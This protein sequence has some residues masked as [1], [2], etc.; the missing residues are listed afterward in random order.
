MVSEFRI[1]FFNRLELLSVQGFFFA[2]KLHPFFSA[3]NFSQSSAC[4]ELGF[5]V[6]RAQDTFLNHLELLSVLGFFKFDNVTI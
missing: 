4:L 2:A 3:L 5:Y 1:H 6:F